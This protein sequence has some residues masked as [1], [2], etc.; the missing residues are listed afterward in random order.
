MTDFLGTGWSFPIETRAGEI[1][2]V[3]GETDIEQ[4]I[5]LIL[6]TTPGERVMRPEFGCGIHDYVFATIDTTR[7]TLIEDEVSDALTR[8]EPRIELIDVDAQM[9]DRATGKLL[10]DIDYRVR[11]TNNEHNLVYPFYLTE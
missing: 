8:W 7:L 3:D 9:A 5:R 2:L 6:S 4:A 11:Q 1:Q 10:V